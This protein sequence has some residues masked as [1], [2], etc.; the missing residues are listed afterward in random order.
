M[1]S[2][3]CVTDWQFHRPTATV[4][5]SQEVSGGHGEVGGDPSPWRCTLL[6]VHIAGSA[7]CR[8]ENRDGELTHT[9]W[10]G[11]WA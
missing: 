5:L 7:F 8:A 4:K 1:K 10:E 2:A 11:A 9:E 6:E 3:F